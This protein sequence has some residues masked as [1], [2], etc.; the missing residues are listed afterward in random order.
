MK[1]ILFVVLLCVFGASCEDKLDITPKGQTVLNTVDDL[2]TLLNQDYKIVGPG[3]D[4][5]VICNESYSGLGENVY[6]ALENPNSLKYAYLTYDASVDRAALTTTDERYTAIY[7]FINYM[8]VI[9]SKL[10]DAEGDAERKERIAAEARIMRAYLHW[11]LVNIH[12][13]QY[14]ET[15]AETAGGIAYVTDTDVTKTKE[16]KTLADV[17]RLLLEDCSEANIKKLPD[18]A[19]NVTRAGKAWGY[20]VR[21]KVL[22][23]MKNY[24]DALPC[25]LESIKYNP[26]IEDRSVIPENGGKWDLP[27]TA[28]NNLLY[29]AQNMIGVFTEILSRETAQMFETG[30]YVRYHSILN[31]GGGDDEE[32]EDYGEDYAENEEY[33]YDG[34]ED[35]NEDEGYDEDEGAGNEG[36]ESYVDPWPLSAWS[37]MFGSMMGG[38]DGSLMWFGMEAWANTNGITSERMYYTA[39]ECYIR[40]GSIGKGLELVDRVREKRIDA[41][42]YAPFEGTVST[43]EDAMALLQKAKWIECIFSYENFFDCKRWNSEEKYKRTITRELPGIGTYTLEPDSPLWILPFPADAVRYNPTL[44]QNY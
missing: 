3:L 35:Y 10:D 39:A 6:A 1:K 29:A 24:N 13:V 31:M 25:A 30:D 17:Y 27:R 19:P 26:S 12:A 8:N 21:A 33:G 42:N 22:M 37:S 9:L 38:V 16:K 4:L 14:D 7:K 11:L 41:D 32:E 34:S 20:A 36:E 5:G 40:T 44:T 23:Q 15:T 28:G 18:V 2:E 43:E